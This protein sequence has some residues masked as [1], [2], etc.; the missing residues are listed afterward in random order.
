MPKSFSRMAILSPRSRL[1]FK[2]S[3]GMV[4]QPSTMNAPLPPDATAGS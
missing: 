1:F 4:S 3:F 2:N